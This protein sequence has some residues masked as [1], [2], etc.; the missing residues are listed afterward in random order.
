MVARPVDVGSVVRKG[1]ELAT[2]DPAVQVLEV[3]GAEAA[4]ANAEAQLANAEAEEGRQR[5]LVAAQH[6]AAR[7]SST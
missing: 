5:D 7:R 6:H 4:V 3:R 2:L 1:D